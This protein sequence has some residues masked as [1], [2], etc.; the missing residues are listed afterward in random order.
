M[1]AALY[2]IFKSN[3]KITKKLLNYSFQ[4]KYYFIYFISPRQ[5]SCYHVT[6][7]PFS[8][9]GSLQ[10]LISSV[11]LLMLVVCIFSCQRISKN[12]LRLFFRSPL[13]DRC[14][15]SRKLARRMNSLGVRHDIIAIPY[16]L[17]QIIG[18]KSSLINDNIISSRYK[19]LDEK[20]LMIHHV[21]ASP[22]MTNVGTLESIG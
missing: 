12:R 18:I 15:V 16:P 22:F 3:V 6:F 19:K 7:F 14:H 5:V 21:K 8:L 20:I 13:Q 2:K 11:H 4:Q 10:V 1:T 17:D 9:F